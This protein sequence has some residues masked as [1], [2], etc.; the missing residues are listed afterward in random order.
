MY[1]IKQQYL[2]RLKYLQNK[3]KMRRE[4]DTKLWKT[5]NGYV[6]T[7]PKRIVKKWELKVGDE[8]TIIIKKE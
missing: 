5:G 6:I 3:Y 1:S 4:V 2:Y 7:I 8:L